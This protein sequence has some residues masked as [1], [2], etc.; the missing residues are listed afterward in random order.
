M[1]HLLYTHSCT[2]DQKRVGRW[3]RTNRYA[4]P[5]LYPAPF[6]PP[7]KLDPGATPKRAGLKKVIILPRKVKRKNNTQKKTSNYLKAHNR[8]PVM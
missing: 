1:K 8:G 3:S 5:P 7:F 4:T 2:G 6:M